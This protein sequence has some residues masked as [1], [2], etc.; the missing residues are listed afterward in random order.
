MSKVEY[1]SADT[2][3]DLLLNDNN[4]KTVQEFKYIGS[5]I[6]L[7]MKYKLYLLITRGNIFILVCFQKLLLV[8]WKTTFCVNVFYFIIAFFLIPG[9]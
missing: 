3:A 1:V 8:S 4:P 6:K 7:K 2:N 9:I 5:S